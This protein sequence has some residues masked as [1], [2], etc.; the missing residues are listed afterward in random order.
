MRTHDDH[1][2]RSS[3]TLL[4]VLGAV[5]YLGRGLRPGFGVWDAVEEALRW[6]TAH[7]VAGDDEALAKSAAA[8]LPWDDTDLLRTALERLVL[9]H[10]PSSETGETTGDALDVALRTWLDVMAERYNDGYGWSSVF[11]RQRYSSS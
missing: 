1:R 8:E 6:H 7:L 10:P 9:H 4:Q 5:D 3:E 2:P 11:V